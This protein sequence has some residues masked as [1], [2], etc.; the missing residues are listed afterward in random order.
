[1]QFIFKPQR[2][3]IGEFD[4]HL[5]DAELEWRMITDN[6]IK[7][8]NEYFVEGLFDYTKNIIERE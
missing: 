5:R 8:V 3:I 7:N 2:Y 6:D 4:K 1:M